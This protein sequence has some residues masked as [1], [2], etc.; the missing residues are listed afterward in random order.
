MSRL[1]FEIELWSRKGLDQLILE[2]GYE[3]NTT[4]NVFPL[5]GNNMLQLNQ[6]S[7]ESTSKN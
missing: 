7:R 4:H 3:A 6:Q 2:V 1:T 5:F